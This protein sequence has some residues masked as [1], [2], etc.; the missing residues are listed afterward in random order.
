[1]K[2]VVAY[3][4]FEQHKDAIDV[5][6]I[7]RWFERF[8]G[9]NFYSKFSFELTIFKERIQNIEAMFRTSTPTFP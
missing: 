8:T 1:M 7:A 4:F 3:R 2:R 9:R 6:F 5:S